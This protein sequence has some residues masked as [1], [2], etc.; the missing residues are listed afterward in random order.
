M[1]Y[2]QTLA[3]TL[4]LLIFILITL[5]L[6]EGVYSNTDV[7]VRLDWDSYTNKPLAPQ[8]QDC[9]W[10][11]GE[12]SIERF[13]TGDDAAREFLY[14]GFS[15]RGG[16]ISAIVLGIGAFV[17]AIVVGDID[18]E[19]EAKY[20]EGS[21]FHRGNTKAFVTGVIFRLLV[22]GTAL[23]MT[24]SSVCTLGALLYQGYVPSAGLD[25]G[26]EDA[27]PREL[28]K[29]CSDLDD[30]VVHRSD[31][32]KASLFFSIASVFFVSVMS[33]YVHYDKKASKEV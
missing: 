4:V 10:S 23:S 3:A 25:F 1:A 26:V 14:G 7:N 2:T 20:E 33:Y 29:A 24:I 5:V 13:T 19:M 6:N 21:W 16:T 17:I 9:T 8:E 27:N 32:L 15:A 18:T 22:V 12:L 30:N 31:S 28:P 11:R